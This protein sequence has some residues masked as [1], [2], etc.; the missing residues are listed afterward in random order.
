VRNAAQN[1][2]EAKEEG[3]Y[4]FEGFHWVGFKEFTMV[5]K[6]RSLL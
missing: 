5:T 4:E 6:V 1:H 3:Q 2:E